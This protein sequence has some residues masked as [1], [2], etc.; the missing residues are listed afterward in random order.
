MVVVIS[1][2]IIRILTLVSIAVSASAPLT[3]GFPFFF[4]FE[5][6]FPKKPVNVAHV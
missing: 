1:E 3:I 4:L 5:L 2:E 6:L